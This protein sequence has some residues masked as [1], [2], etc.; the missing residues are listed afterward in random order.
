[1]SGWGEG[2]DLRDRLPWTVRLGIHSGLAGAARAGGDVPWPGDQSVC[3]QHQLSHNIA[4]CVM[5]CKTERERERENSLTCD[6]DLR[7]RRRSFGEMIKLARL[8]V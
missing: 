8:K 2:R 3:E 6:C 4:N 5:F 7:R 1:M